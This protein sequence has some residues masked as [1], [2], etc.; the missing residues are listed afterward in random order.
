MSNVGAAVVTA[1]GIQAIAEAQAQ[2]RSIQ[3]RR[4]GFSSQ[5]YTVDP[6]LTEIACWKEDA[7]DVTLEVDAD[8]VEFDCIVEPEEASSYTRFVGIY[9][10]DGTLF[11]VAKPPFALPPGL[12]QTIKVQIRYQQISEVMSFQYLPTDEAE[13]WASVIM[14]TLQQIGTDILTHDMHMLGEKSRTGIVKIEG[15]DI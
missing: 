15:R 10:D 8:T 4:F 6:M 11:A 14:N 9:L 1:A 5:E 13:Q 7:I 12:R 2:G 3:P